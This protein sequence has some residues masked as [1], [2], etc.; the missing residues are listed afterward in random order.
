MG[1]TGGMFGGE[2]TC[3]V[4]WEKLEEK[5]SLGKPRHKWK[6]IIRIDLGEVHWEGLEWIS[7]AQDSYN[8]WAP[9]STS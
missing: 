8:W 5:R 6:Y 3:T 7:L 4:F 2:E 1:G 9:V